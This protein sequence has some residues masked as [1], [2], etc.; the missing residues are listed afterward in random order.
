MIA[1]AHNIDGTCQTIHIRPGFP[2]KDQVEEQ[3][4]I[5]IFLVR[6]NF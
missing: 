3:I 5:L 4:E 6:L 1:E 2:A